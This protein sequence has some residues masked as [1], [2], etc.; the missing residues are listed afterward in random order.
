MLCVLSHK[1]HTQPGRL[2]DTMDQLLRSERFSGRFPSLL[3]Q[4]L[5]NPDF[6]SVHPFPLTDKEPLFYSDILF[7]SSKYLDAGVIF[8][9]GSLS[10]VSI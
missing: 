8:K 1:T 6:Q 4:T 7:T 3:H 9:E 5:L 10:S 2:G